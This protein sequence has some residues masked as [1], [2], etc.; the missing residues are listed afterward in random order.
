MKY[1]KKEREFLGSKYKIYETWGDV[2][3]ADLNSES[4]E[5]LFI[6]DQEEYSDMKKFGRSGDY[7]PKYFISNA[8]SKI[9]ELDKDKLKKEIELLRSKLR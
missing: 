3:E 5:L 8:E 1:G 4:E 9:R 6:L 2:I 7:V